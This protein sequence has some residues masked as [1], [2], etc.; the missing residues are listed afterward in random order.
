[1]E[2]AIK[3]QVSEKTNEL[4][5]NLTSLTKDDKGKMKLMIFVINSI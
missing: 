4:T 1:M 2:D 3:E 5:K